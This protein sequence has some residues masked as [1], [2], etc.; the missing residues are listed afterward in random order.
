MPPP[1][2]PLCCCCIR[3]A[4]DAAAVWH[5]PHIKCLLTVCMFAGSLMTAIGHIFCAVVGAGV[6]GK[7]GRLPSLQL[8]SH[9]W[10][11]ALPPSTPNP[12]G[13]CYFIHPAHTHLTSSA[14]PLPPLAAGLPYSLAW[15][16]WVAGPILLVFFY[17]VS[18]W[19]AKMMAGE[20]HP[21][22]RQLAWLRRPR[23][24]D[25]RSRCS[26]LS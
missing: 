26:A 8:G 10:Q 5:L 1:A 15:L 20:L 18:L 7:E 19:A 21:R 22:A 13:F 11:A 17:V 25:E 4:T 16:G 6:L 24:V 14:S 2:L 3:S 12:K 23:A 9:F